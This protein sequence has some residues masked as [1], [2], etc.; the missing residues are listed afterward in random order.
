MNFLDQYTSPD[1]LPQK[2]AIFPLEGALLLP[3]AQLPLNIFE[4]RYVQMISDA[5]S[6][7]RIIGMIQPEPGVSSEALD[8]PTVQVPTYSTGCAGRITS[9]S[10]TPDGRLLISLSGISRFSII[11]EMARVTPYRICETD[12]VQFKRDLEPGIGE[13]AVDRDAL[14][15]TFRKYLSAN[16]MDADWDEVENATTESL[17]NTLCVISPFAAREKQAMLEAATLSERANVLIALTEMALA[18]GISTENENARL[19]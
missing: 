16:S 8:D 12:F 3:R 15:E 19:Q 7:D 1:D 2:I 4:P 11:Q 10:E 17:V 9:Y 14:I 13:N 6:A 5:M 18:S